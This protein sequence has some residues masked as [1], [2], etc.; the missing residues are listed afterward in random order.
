[1]D[2]P[3]TVDDLTDGRGKKIDGRQSE[4]DARELKN[5]GRRSENDARELKIDGRRLRKLPF[6]K[7]A[8]CNGSFMKL[9]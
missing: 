6:V 7:Q 1:M 8:Q 5:N 4:N 3:T 2:E 9:V